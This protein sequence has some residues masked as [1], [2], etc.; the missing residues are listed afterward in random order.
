[1]CGDRIPASGHSVNGINGIGDPQRPRHRWSVRFVAAS[2][3]EGESVTGKGKRVKL[4][5]TGKGG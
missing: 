2:V 5:F 4:A 3:V 1:M